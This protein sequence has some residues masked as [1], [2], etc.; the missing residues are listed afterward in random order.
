MSKENQGSPGLRSRKKGFT[1][2]MFND[3]IEAQNSKNDPTD[4]KTIQTY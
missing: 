3:S 2:G 4:E 1:V